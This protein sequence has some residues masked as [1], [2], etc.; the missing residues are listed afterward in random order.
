[1]PSYAHK[2]LVERILRIDQLPCEKPDFLKW[3]EAGQHLQFL[4]TNAASDEVIVYGSG[5]FT[6]IYSM[7]VPNDVLFP[8]KEADLLQW[9]GNPFTS[10]ASYSLWC[11]PR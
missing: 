9:S 8:I 2:K 1:M 7:V 11:W 5:P 10:I 4:V 3:I 6:F